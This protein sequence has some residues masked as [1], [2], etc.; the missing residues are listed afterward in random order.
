MKKV[1][2]R[3]KAVSRTA[4][5]LI[6]G[7]SLLGLIM[8]ESWQVTRERPFQAEK[9]AAARLAADAMETLY[10]AREEVG[11]AI[12][13]T[14]DPTESGLI[15]V[16][17]SPVTSISGHLIAKQTT[18]NPNFAAVMVDMLKRAD[19]GEGDVVALGVSG[20]FPALNVCTYAALEVLKAKPIVIASAAASQFGA[21]VPDLLWIDMERVLQDQ[22]V[23]NIRSV[24]ASIGGYEDRGL[25]MSEEGLALIQKAIARN[26]LL[27]LEAE[28]FEDC[29]EE[30]MQIY[31]DYAKGKP[32]KAYINVGGGTV[33]VGRS[34]GKKMFHPG[35]NRRTPDKLRLVDGVMPRFI[36][37]GV[38][39]IHMVQVAELAERY[40]MQISP[41][42]MPQVGEA[43]VFS[44]FDY[45]RW[46]AATILF[47]EVAL[48]YTFIRSDV[49]FRLLRMSPQRKE[50]P[51]PEPMV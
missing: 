50:Q 6:A 33:S 4:L 27:Q 19:V 7:F 1:Y 48:L 37:E 10:F 43:T 22:G 44:G 8:V 24:A 51:A 25:G 18:I 17:M 14:I 15:G 45:N 5:L 23:M 38:P 34:L 3:P 39:V 31:K 16:T 30:R 20:S 11:P 47:I 26:G 46:L 21:N 13:R 41:P 42:T 36:A 49:G 29:I 40:G 32:I 12:D 35:L 9:L 2:W 28:E